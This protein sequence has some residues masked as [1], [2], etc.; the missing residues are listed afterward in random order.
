[1][2]ELLELQNNIELLDKNRL[3]LQ[4]NL[5]ALQDQIKLSTELLLNKNDYGTS[6]YKRDR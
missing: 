1:M 5:Q 2:K 4:K 6:E 3:E